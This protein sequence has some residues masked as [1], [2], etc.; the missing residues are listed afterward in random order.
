V[1]KAKGKKPAAENP[2]NAVAA[3]LRVPKG[4]VDLT[5]YDTRATPGFTGDKLAGKQQ[6][7]A[8]AA[9]LS[10]LQERL[11]ANG[12]TGGKRR[13]LLVVQ[14]M[15]TSGKGG[16]M[17]HAV[18]L[19]DP[20]GVRIKS[21]KAPTVEEKRR[22]FLWRVRQALPHAG[23]VGVFDRSHY[24]DVLVA[25]V[26]EL[27][28]PA[29]IERRYGAINDFEA[30]LV[31]SGCA[32]IKVMLHISPDE[33]K[34][35]LLARLDDPTKHWKYN[36]GDVGERLLWEDYQQAYEIALERCNTDAAPW[37]VVSADRK[38]YRNWAVT[39]LLVEHLQ[40]MGIEWP[41]AGFD[42]EKERERLAAT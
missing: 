16:V 23:E 42:V 17:R 8:M 25:R 22:G 20:Q 27:T 12:R 5:I 13:L 40:R 37:H 2:P 14:G 39:T 10:E 15:D 31:E 30:K 38:W 29:T 18:G 24:E 34:A 35:R 11:F 41:K 3:L 1:A 36:P 4:P 9:P 26:R 6:L 32:V 21:F 19:M 28:T 33:Q 7:A